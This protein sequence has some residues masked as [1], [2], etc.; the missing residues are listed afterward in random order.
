[1][2]MYNTAALLADPR[3]TTGDQPHHVPEGKHREIAHWINGTAVAGTS[4]RTS[5]VCNPA[6]GQVQAK[7]PLASADISGLGRCT[8]VTLRACCSSSAT[9]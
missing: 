3:P 5:D 7:V 6:T 4:G 1:M 8:T 9:V 2:F